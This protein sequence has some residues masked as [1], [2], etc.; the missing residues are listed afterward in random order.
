M[1]AVCASWVTI[2]PLLFVL[3]LIDKEG[4]NYGLIDDD[5]RKKQDHYQTR[6]EE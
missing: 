1:G 2:C 4:V 5:S 3:V 6:G